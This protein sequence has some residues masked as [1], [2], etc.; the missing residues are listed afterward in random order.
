MCLMAVMIRAG[1]GGEKEGMLRFSQP[2]GQVTIASSNVMV[3]SKAVVMVTESGCMP[4][5]FDAKEVTLVDNLSSASAN[6]PLAMR[7]RIDL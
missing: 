5:A 7:S 4:W 3:S 6:A 2:K 1:R